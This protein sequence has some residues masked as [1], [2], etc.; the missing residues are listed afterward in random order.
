M[1]FS[2]RWTL[3]LTCFV[4]L[5]GTGLGN[6]VDSK[7]LLQAARL[8]HYAGHFAEAEVL[9]RSALEASRRQGRKAETAFT[10]NY[11]G[12]VYLSEDRLAEAESAFREAVAL[13]KESPSAGIGPIVALR[14]L[15]TALS[16][17]GR[18]DSALST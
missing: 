8:Q 17:E 3:R 5:I 12:D 4:A 11:L 6:P 10:L 15:G 1:M 14:G 7:D 16:L 2:M 9:L 18:E 13:Y